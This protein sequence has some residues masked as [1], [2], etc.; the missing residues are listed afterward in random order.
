MKKYL[1][2]DVRVGISK[3]GI[4]CGPVSGSVIGEVVLRS[5]DG[6]ATYHSLAEVEGTLNFYASEV[7]I[8]QGLIDEDFD[9]PEFAELMD[10]SFD[11]SYD[12][13]HDFYEE[14]NAMQPLSVLAQIRKYLAYMVQ[15]DW[16]KVNQLK[17]E[18]IGKDV[19][20]FE[21][22]VCEAEAEYMEENEEDEGGSQ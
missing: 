13:Y 12:N 6:Q 4:A 22:P 19:G 14:V 10:N 7:S 15:V 1:I 20:E 17:A 2:E 11:A 8:Y 18:T 5:E 3:G 21:L 16:P 9:N